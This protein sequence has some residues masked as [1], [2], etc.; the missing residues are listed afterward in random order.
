MLK[1]RPLNAESIIKI[2]QAD[3]NLSPHPEDVIDE[4]GFIS[5]NGF[6][7]DLTTV[8]KFEDTEIKAVGDTRAENIG[9]IL[10]TNPRALHEFLKANRLPTNTTICFIGSAT[11][12]IQEKVQTEIEL[13]KLMQEKKKDPM[14]Y[15]RL[16]TKLRT[17]H[18]HGQNYIDGLP[19]Y[20]GMADHINGHNIC[21]IHLT[22]ARRLHR[23]IGKLETTAI[24]EQTLVVSSL[25][26]TLAHEVKHRKDYNYK[27][28]HIAGYITMKTLLPSVITV[29]IATL[30]TQKMK[31]SRL[32]LLGLTALASWI[33]F[34]KSAKRR[35]N[36]R[37]NNFL[38]A[39]ANREE[40]RVF[41]IVAQNPDTIP[42]I[43]RIGI[44]DKPYY[45][46]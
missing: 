20:L 16:V 29:A 34:D 1:S 3:L 4:T 42:Q 24:P 32:S 11:G 35:W 31:K 38:E 5:L 40:E 46:K 7:E 28:L 15:F 18:I 36:S 30:L 17:Y 25:L 37:Y 13:E 10:Q 45:E 9:Y 22:D 6:H 33:Y 21:S 41:N 23:Q 12:G 8:G 26:R 39:S 43:F 27:R 14:E 44:D 2:Q 19:L